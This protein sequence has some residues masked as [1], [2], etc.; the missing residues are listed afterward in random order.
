MAMGF[1]R[2]FSQAVDGTRAWEVAWNFWKI[3]RSRAS[4]HT[5]LVKRLTSAFWIFGTQRFFAKM[6]TFHC[7]LLPFMYLDM[8]VSQCCLSCSRWKGFVCTEFTCSFKKPHRTPQSR[9]ASSHQ[10]T[11][12]AVESTPRHRKRQRPCGAFKNGFAQDKPKLLSW[13]V[14]VD[15]NQ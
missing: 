14:L 4:E 13:M 2:H 6:N 1:P 11:S 10:P 8:L 9:A 7:V 12:H 15:P 5:N 3:S